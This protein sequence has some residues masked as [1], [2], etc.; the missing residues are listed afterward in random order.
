[1]SDLARTLAAAWDTL[2]RGVAD[3]AAPARHPVL[4]TTG[5]DGP[6]A[7]LLVL[8]GA[9]RGAGT[10]TLYTDAA[11]AKV[12]ELARDPRAALVVWD[13]AARLQ[14]RLRAHVASRPGT[15]AEWAGLS[16]TA[17]AVYGGDPAPG[18]AIPAPEAHRP[19]PDPSRFTVL[20]ARIDGIETL[21]LGEPHERAR[22]CRRDGFAGAWLAP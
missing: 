21:S 4:A 22:F 15:P 1:M 17:R 2:E 9:D 18:A 14:I 11:T 13:A 3:H 8:R 19:M 12:R 20:V 5:P 7:R 6:E 10:L 16:D